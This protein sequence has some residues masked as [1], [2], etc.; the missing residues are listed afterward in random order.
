MSR[1]LMSLTAGKY[2]GCFPASFC[3][4]TVVRDCSKIGKKEMLRVVLDQ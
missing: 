3:D 1:Q 2:A 4:K